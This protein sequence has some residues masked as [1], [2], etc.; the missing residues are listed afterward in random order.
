MYSRKWAF[1]REQMW[2][3]ILVETFQIWHS[4]LV[5][6]HTNTNA[7]FY[8]NTNTNTKIN[9]DDYIG[10]NISKSNVAQFASKGAKKYK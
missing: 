9:T 5:R 8:P 7:I 3:I 4:L 1:M 6:V 2:M 10:G